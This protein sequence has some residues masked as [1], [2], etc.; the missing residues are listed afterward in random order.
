MSSNDHNKMM[1]A[2]FEALFKTKPNESTLLPP[3]PLPPPPTPLSSYLQSF[4]HSSALGLTPPPKYPLAPPLPSIKSERPDG[5]MG[6]K[7]CESLMRLIMRKKIE[8]N[9]GRVLPNLED[10]AIL[11]GRTIRAAFLY[12]DLDGFTQLV[13]SKPPEITLLLHQAFVELLGRITTYY[14]GSVVN[15]AGDRILSVFDRAENDLSPEPIQQ[16]IAAALWMQT[17]LQRVVAPELKKLGVDEDVKAAMGIDYGPVVAGCVGIRNNKHFEFFGNAANNAAK[18]QE[19]GKGNEV[20]ISR[21]AFLFRPEF[22][23][24]GTWY[25][26]DE[27]NHIRL[28]QRFADSVLSPPKP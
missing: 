18:L 24:N 28:T 1:A 13:A 8:L 11:E 19:I 16:A 6:I 9:S 3:P 5:S 22:L 25:P 27:V 10:L 7:H 26:I 23:N 2:L 21:L 14:G 15:C 20:V 17:I 12:S 4:G